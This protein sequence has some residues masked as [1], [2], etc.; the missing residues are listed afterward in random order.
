VKAAIK[1]DQTIDYK[2]RA[3]AGQTM[4]VK[5][6]TGHGANN[7]EDACTSPGWN[8]APIDGH[9]SDEDHERLDDSRG[10]FDV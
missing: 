9:G 7:E 2:L 10:C 3:K 1:G 4:R 5:L 6:A 8:V